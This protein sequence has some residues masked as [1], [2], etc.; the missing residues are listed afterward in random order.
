[1]LHFD[2]STTLALLP[3]TVYNI[4]LALGPLIASSVSE[5]YGRRPVYLV[6][7]L[8]AMVFTAL[9]GSAST[10]RTLTVA[11]LLA[12]LFG[13]PMTSVV[14]GTLNDV[15]GR[16]RDSIATTFMALFA[17]MMIWGSEIGPAVGAAIMRDRNDWR[18]TFWVTLLMLGASSLVWLCPETYAPAILRR[19]AKKQG[20][21][22]PP[23]GHIALVLKVA[24]GRPLHMLAVEPIIFPTALISSISISMVFFF[25][26]AF[27]LVFEEL[28]AFSPCHV[29]LSFLSLFVG[30]MLGLV[31]MSVLDK[32]AYQVAKAKAESEGRSVQP[33]E[34]LYPAMLGGILL[35][36]T[37][38]W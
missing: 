31:I 18:W 33:E 23:R 14:S 22:V 26:V 13:A 24:C 35:P 10:F 1:M 12:S 37:L 30:S 15:W 9:A 25:Y 21:P 17:G 32:R 34:R 8:G 11:R 27:P 38:F 3:I 28:Y 36:V 7:L 6:S 2:V 16:E 19:R 20:L 5:I 29:G 4:G